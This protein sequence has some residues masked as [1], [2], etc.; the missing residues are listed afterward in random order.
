MEETEENLNEVVGRLQITVYNDCLS[1]EHT[2]N[3]ST[4]DII[5]LFT[6]TLEKLTGA[7]EITEDRVVH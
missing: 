1:V 6:A 2:A 4:E 3:L 5:D 7:L